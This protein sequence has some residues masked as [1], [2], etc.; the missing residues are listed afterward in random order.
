MNPRMIALACG[1]RIPIR[2]E[3][4]H[5]LFAGGEVGL[6]VPILIEWARERRPGPSP[7]AVATSLRAKL[8]ELGYTNV[9]IAQVK[10]IPTLTKETH[11]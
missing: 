3:D 7:L 4:N 6:G 9:R 2:L 10:Y 1:G 11:A 8:R 5:L